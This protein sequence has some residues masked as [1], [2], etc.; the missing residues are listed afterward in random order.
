MTNIARARPPAHPTNRSN[1]YDPQCPG[2]NNGL[3]W[4]C[5]PGRPRFD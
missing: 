5:T 1:Q 2:L 3:E 4:P